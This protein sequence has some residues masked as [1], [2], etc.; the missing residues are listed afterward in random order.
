MKAAFCALG[1]KVNQYEADSYA[2]MFKKKGYEIGS[3]DDTCDIYVVNTCSVTNI[4]DRKSRQMLRRAKKLNPDAIVVATGCYAQV[5]AEDVKNLPEVD[6]LI[7]TSKRHLIVEIVESFMR[8][9]NIDDVPDIMD[10]REFEEL[11]CDGKTERT[12]AYIK[13]QDGCDNYCS[14]CIVPYARGHVRSRKIENIIKEA[15]R[16]S[17]KGFQEIVLTGISVAFYGKD[18]DYSVRLIDVIKSVSE[19]E[20]VK[21][22]RIS[23]IDPQAFTDEFINELSKID[24]LCRHFHI[25]LQSGSTSVLKRM[26]RKYSAEEYL[27]VLKKIRKSMPDALITTDIICG[28]PEETQNEA[29]ETTDFVKKAGFLKV[30]VFPYSQRTGTRASEM[31]QIPIPVREERAKALSKTAEEEG[32][33]VQKAFVGTVQS[34]L[35]EKSENGFSEGLAKNY[36]RVYVKSEKPLDSLILDTEITKIENGKIYGEIKNPPKD[37]H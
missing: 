12:R 28:F 33:K 29:K 27:T 22:V 20:K 5:K 34:V 19:I 32:E 24:K 23:S 1:C 7:G 18:S 36:L 9:E 6:V 16:L 17:E 3:F 31:P 26:N 11:E 2:H 15:K 8:G 37:S 13:I 10:E 14:Y 35:F 21:R 25:S 4:G 30:H